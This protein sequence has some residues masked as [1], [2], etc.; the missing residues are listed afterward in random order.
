MS[1][2]GGDPLVAIRA[3]WEPVP[4]QG[5]TGGWLVT[6][7]CDIDVLF[8]E[9]ARLRRIEEAA[10]ALRSRTDGL[11]VHFT[12]GMPYLVVKPDWFHALRAALEEK[13]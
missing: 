13:P 6:A 4:P 5:I 3:R 1:P 10:R 8:D 7:R 2:S 9:I 11:T 12:G